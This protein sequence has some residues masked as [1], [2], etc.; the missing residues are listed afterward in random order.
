MEYVAKNI[1]RAV[2][3]Q[4]LRYKDFAVVVPSSDDYE[5]D[6]RNVFTRYDVPYFLDKKIPFSSA[7][8]A[9]YILSAIRC[10]SDGFDFSDVNAL[11]KNPLFYKT[12]E[13]YE[14]VQLFE[15]YVL[16]NALSNKL[17]KKFKNEAAESVRKRIFDV[18]APFSGLDGKDVKEYVA[19]LNAFWK[20]K[21]SRNIRK[22]SR[23]KS[24]PSKARLPNSFTISSSI[25]STKCRS[26]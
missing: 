17:H 24:K 26:S 4:K 20:T 12:P 6:V 3:E 21:K 2:I 13:G 10:A 7:P 15:N 16:K 19:A 18:A 5:N 1:R 22:P 25:S 9:R 8:Q 23:T 14:S 11:I